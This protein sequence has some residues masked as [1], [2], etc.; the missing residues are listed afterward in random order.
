MFIL[1][2]HSIRPFF[3]ML[4]EISGGADRTSAGVLDLNMFC[5]VLQT[6]TD[7]NHM[8]RHNETEF[9]SQIIPCNIIES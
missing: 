3:F 5:K 7:A 6:I 2:T 1:D 9:V 8:T 4:V